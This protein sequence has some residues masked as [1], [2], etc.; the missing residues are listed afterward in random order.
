M[1]FEDVAW[2]D[3]LFEK[4]MV[5]IQKA[6]NKEDIIKIIFERHAVIKKAK[7]DLADEMVDG[8]SL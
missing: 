6:E 8:I 7:F 2:L 3:T 5:K 1:N 4:M